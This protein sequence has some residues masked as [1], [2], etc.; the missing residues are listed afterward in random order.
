MLSF[1]EKPL[2]WT[3]DEKGVVKEVLLCSVIKTKIIGTV[4]IFLM[5]RRILPRKEAFI[6]A[7]I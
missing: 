5:V 6:T 2:S 7:Q 3:I 1:L 4:H